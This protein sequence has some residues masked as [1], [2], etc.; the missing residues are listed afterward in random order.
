MAAQGGFGGGMGGGFGG[1]G[2]SSSQARVADGPTRIQAQAFGGGGQG[3][4]FQV[5]SGVELVGDHKLR[6]RFRNTN[7]R[8]AL[9]EVFDAAGV[10]FTL[11][12]NVP[13]TEVVT[14]SFNNAS[15]QTV[16]E[17]ILRSLSVKLTYRI[18]GGV[19][20]IMAVETPVGS[21]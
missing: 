2:V 11:S 9:A 21:H 13:Y 12:S 19:F 15:V 5:S 20:T 6:V 18:E 4:A 8:E 14:C 16:V 17:S 1:G 7:L 3:T 10:D